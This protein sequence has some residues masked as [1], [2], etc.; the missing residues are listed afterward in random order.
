MKRKIRLGPNDPPV[1]AA[2][3]GCDGWADL[4]LLDF[5][6]SILDGHLKLPFDCCEPASLRVC[7][8]DE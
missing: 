5:Q 8:S 1:L 4:V 3:V 7:E 6:P 2:V